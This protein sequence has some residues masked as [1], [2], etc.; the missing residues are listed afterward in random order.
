MPLLNS[1]KKQKIEKR[2]GIVLL[3]FGQITVWASLFYIFPAML[4]R[5]ESHYDW[6]KA[7]LTGALTLALLCSAI[8]S[9]LVGR[10]IDQGAGPW[11]LA[12]GAAFGGFC[13]WL[14][15]LV[16]YLWQFYVLW[17]LI[18]FAL[19]A[20]LYEPCFMLITRA[21][22][23]QAKRSIIVVT[24]IAGFASS[25]SFPVSHLIAE[26]FGS[27]MVIVAFA[28]TAIFISAPVLYLGG[29]LVERDVS[30][31]NRSTD[32]TASKLGYLKNKLL[33]KLGVSFAVLAVVHGAT[34]HHLLALLTDKG[35]VIGSAVLVASLIGPMQVV[36]RLFITAFQNS[37]SHPTIA[38]YCFALMGL[39]MLLLYF[40]SV[41][42]AVAILFAVVFGGSYGIVSIIRPV[43]ARDFLGEYEFGT[44]S[45]LLAFFYLIGSAIAPYFASLVWSLG[46]YNLLIP[47]LFAFAVLG[48]LL[49]YS[50]TKTPGKY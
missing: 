11:L 5:W 44:K 17:A 14:L 8:S 3:A 18:G 22:G 35:L 37:L 45:G 27:N 32:N 43:I 15:T 47:I 28:A 4:L 29:R 42:L 1:T 24:L 6:S 9:P 25:I 16:T 49:I 13:L 33:L 2:P 50:V 12:V 7:A 30:D 23:K 36:G 48:L 41:G 26:Y 38:K 46:G 39:S 31:S 10:K 34:L 20:C 21:Y 40:S 19:S